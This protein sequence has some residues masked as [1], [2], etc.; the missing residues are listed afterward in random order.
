MSKKN[1]ASVGIRKDVSRVGNHMNKEY[2]KSNHSKFRNKLLTNLKFIEMKKTII[3]TIIAFTNYISNAQIQQ[4]FKLDIGGIKTQELALLNKPK[5]KYEKIYELE[6]MPSATCFCVI[7]YNNLDGQ[8]SRSGECADLT[9]EL[10]V[11]YGGLNPQKEDNRKNCAQRCGDL[12]W[13]KMQ[14]DPVF[15]QGIANCACSAGAGSGTMIRAF[16]GVGTREYR[17]GQTLGTLINIPEITKTTCTCPTGWLSNTSNIDG[18]VTTDGNCKKHVCGPIGIS[19]LPPNG[20][21]IGNWGFTWGN[22]IWAIGTSANGGKASC[23]TII[24][25]QKDCRIQ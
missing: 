15:K 7:S 22:G 20:T 5:I 1:I 21:P 2:K 3:L 10:G 16:G 18:G 4:N 12:A 23:T 17:Q 25:Q 24:T 13:S 11:T 6:M 19:P 9:F 8:N 14:N